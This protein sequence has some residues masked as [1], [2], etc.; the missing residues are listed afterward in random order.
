MKETQKYSVVLLFN[1]DGSKVLLQ[2]KDRTAFAG[3]LNGVGGKIEKEEQPVMGAF[4]GIE[5]ETTLKR[6][7]IA[8]FA[9]L[10]TLTLPEQC[11]TANANKYPELWFFG[12]VVED[13]DL[14]QK[15]ED[16]TEEVGWYNI[17]A[18]GDGTIRPV[19][20][21]E[22]DGKIEHMELAGDGDLLYFIGVGRRI[23][24]NKR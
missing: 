24:F 9:W 1:K 7:K 6:N 15:A 13:E 23:L 14:V 8:H 5:E 16:A 4:R 2:T 20:V 10:G 18:D 11:D 19:T 22:R 21:F 3:M 17:T 12:G